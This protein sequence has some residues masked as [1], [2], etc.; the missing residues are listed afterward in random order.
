MAPM[1][2]TKYTKRIME[3]IE[4]NGYISVSIHDPLQWNRR[5]LLS[6]MESE[7]MIEL[8]TP[9]IGSYMHYNKKQMAQPAKE[10][11]PKRSW[12]KVLFNLRLR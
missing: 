2:Q 5:K 8:V 1:K 10:T 3:I 4:R 12:W 9:V 6:S 7:G 11:E